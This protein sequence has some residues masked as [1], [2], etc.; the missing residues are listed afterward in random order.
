MKGELTRIRQVMRRHGDGAHAGLD[1]GAR[2]GHRRRQPLLLD[3]ARGPGAAPELGLQVRGPEPQPLPGGQAGLV[4]LARPRGPEPRG[5]E[6]YCGLFRLNGQAKPAWAAFR[7]F[8]RA[9]R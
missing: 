4:Q 6:F 2:L 7:H 5:W 1:L 8:T 9:T 3:H